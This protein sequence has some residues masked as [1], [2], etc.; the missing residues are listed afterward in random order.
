MQT[1][2]E[3][4]A[5]LDPALA[6]AHDL[7]D[8]TSDIQFKKNPEFKQRGRG[9]SRGGLM[10]RGRGLSGQGQGRGSLTRG[11]QRGRGALHQNR[12]RSLSVQTFGGRG[13]G[14]SSGSEGLLHPDYRKQVSDDFVSPHLQESSQSVLVGETSSKHSTED[15]PQTLGQPLPDQMSD[16][17]CSAVS[18]TARSGMVGTDLR[19]K[20]Q[21]QHQKE[22]QR[23]SS[24]S[25]ERRHSKS[26]RSSDRLTQRESESSLGSSRSGD[27]PEKHYSQVRKDKESRRSR[28]DKYRS[29]G[30]DQRQT[31]HDSSPSTYSR[32]S[33]SHSDSKKS[34][35][36]SSERSDSVSQKRSRGDS[37]RH[38]PESVDRCDQRQQKY[39]E[40]SRSGHS[41]LQHSKDS[42]SGRSKK[43]SSSR[44]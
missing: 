8:Q 39:P 41:R 10:G 6:Q 44:E 36:V 27:P 9:N 35:Y 42:S 28:H 38:R 13:V 24:K 34:K 29:D 17:Q 21:L 15:I 3:H 40:S 19:H 12:A 2:D 11:R 1:F 43:P 22:V 14:S 33:Q 26:S 31:S 37:D 16:I 32:L 20:L 5:A 7:A 23:H 18:I 4:S 30:S 25:S